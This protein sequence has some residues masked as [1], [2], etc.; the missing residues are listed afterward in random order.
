MIERIVKNFAPRKVRD[1]ALLSM[2]GVG[3]GL[4]GAGI[5]KIKNGEESQG[6]I[7]ALRGVFAA[8]ATVAFLHKSAQERIQST[9]LEESDVD[10]KILREI[11]YGRPQIIEKHLQTRE[12]T[13]T[14]IYPEVSHTLLQIPDTQGL[15]E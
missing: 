1:V 2:L 7:D 14:Q 12:D 3:L 10:D 9:N 8:A 6:T 5:A 13:A 4:G 15:P 11:F